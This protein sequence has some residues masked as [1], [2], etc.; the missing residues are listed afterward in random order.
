[1]LKELF[2][3]LLQGKSLELDWRRNQR[4]ERIADSWLSFSK[5]IWTLEEISCYSSMDF[6]LGCCQCNSHNSTSVESISRKRAIELV[7]LE[8]KRRLE[9]QQAGEEELLWLQSTVASLSGE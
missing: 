8:A 2:Q 1:M 5:G 6:E 3:R 9:K 7:A 4:G